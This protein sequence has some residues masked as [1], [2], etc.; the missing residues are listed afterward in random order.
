[1]DDPYFMTPEEELRVELRSA[2]DRIALLEG[3]LED[4]QIKIS[5]L[6]GDLRMVRSTAKTAIDVIHTHRLIKA[7]VRGEIVNPHVVPHV[8]EPKPDFEAMRRATSTRRGDL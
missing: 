3:Q 1:M 8:E 2:L 5:D 7:E 4:A 6:E